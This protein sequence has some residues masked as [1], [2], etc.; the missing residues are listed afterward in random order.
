MTNTVVVLRRTD[1]VR[2]RQSHRQKVIVIVMGRCIRV[3]FRTSNRVHLP[4]AHRRGS[5][6]SIRYHN[7]RWSAG[8]AVAVRALGIT[9]ELPVSPDLGEPAS[10]NHCYD[11]EALVNLLYASISG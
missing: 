4:F 2:A 10:S 6:C 9:E 8:D 3:G 1:R 11:H 5:D 7:I